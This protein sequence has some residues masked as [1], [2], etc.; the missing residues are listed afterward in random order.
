MIMSGISG[1]DSIRAVQAVCVATKFRT[2]LTVA[3][4]PI[5]L[6]KPLRSARKSA[7]IFFAHAQ[8]TS[9]D[10]AARAAQRESCCASSE[11]KAACAIIWVE[12]VFSL[13]VISTTAASSVS[14][15]TVAAATSS[16]SG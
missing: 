16:R 15:L 12:T 2:V 5:G 3:L 4:S 13:V 14:V 10:A 7:S 9:S 1:E 11:T 8:V 6:E